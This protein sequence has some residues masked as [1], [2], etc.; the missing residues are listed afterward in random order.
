MTDPN[1]PTTVYLTQP[2][3]DEQRLKEQPKYASNYGKDE[4]YQP[5]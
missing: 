5:M 3:G 1:D 2:V 4:K